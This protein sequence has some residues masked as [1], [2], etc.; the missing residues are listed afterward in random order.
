R[1]VRAHRARRRRDLRLFGPGAHLL[2]RRHPLQHGAPRALDLAAERPVG[3]LDASLAAL[4]AEADGHH[5]L[6]SAALSGA[7][8][9]NSPTI[10]RSQDDSMQ[11]GISPSVDEPVMEAKGQ[12]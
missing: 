11:A 10:G 3:N 9:E 4:T 5:E 6:L 1:R 7:A 12:A 8:P 2:F